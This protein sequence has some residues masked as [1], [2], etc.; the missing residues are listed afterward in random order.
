VDAY[1]FDY[2][3]LM[4]TDDA[5]GDL[6]IREVT[7]NQVVA[8]NLA[9]YR[10]EA[11]MTQKDLGDRIGWSNVAVSEAERSFDGKRIREF[12]AHILCALALALGVPLA[13]LFL[14]PEDDGTGFTYAFAP[15]GWRGEPLP[16][17]V[18]MEALVM[19][20]SDS[21]SSA[22]EGYRHRFRAAVSR[23]LDAEWTET[24]GGWMA[25]VDEPAARADRAERL[26]SRAQ[27]FWDAAEE[28]IEMADAIDP[29]GAGE[30]EDA[31]S[32]LVQDA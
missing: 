16:M 26:R 11:R 23:Y 18:L 14:P 29:K 12:D 4:D 3:R 28:F 21:Q 13:A 22:M 30:K 27:V 24:I 9:W 8:W 1:S 31:V 19:T 5:A 6:P 2:D 17:S 32:G 25:E 7:L 15:P 20:D 10:R